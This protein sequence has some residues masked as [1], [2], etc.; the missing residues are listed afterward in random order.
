MN[1]TIGPKFVL[2]LSIIESLRI[3]PS[4]R[5]ISNNKSLSHASNVPTSIL[6]GVTLAKQS[7]SLVEMLT[8]ILS[9]RSTLGLTSSITVI[10]VVS[11]E[12]LPHSSM[13]SYVIVCFPSGKPLK[14]K[15]LVGFA[16]NGVPSG[17][18]TVA[19]HVISS[20]SLQ[21]SLVVVSI[22]VGKIKSASQN[23]GPV[24]NGP[25]IPG[26]VNAG[27]SSSATLII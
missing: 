19:I 13:S 14:V 1:F 22:G 3:L 2:S 6:S 7:S 21:L 23:H 15:P 12:V 10:D 16:V 8:M 25:S 11:V 24:D 20:T 9:L 27:P 5:L 26:V 17:N 18:V 4:N